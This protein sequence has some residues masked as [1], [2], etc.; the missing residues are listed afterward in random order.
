MDRLR[1]FSA[2]T[3]LRLVTIGRLFF[4]AAPSQHEKCLAITLIQINVNSP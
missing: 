3:V 4:L 1:S 2:L